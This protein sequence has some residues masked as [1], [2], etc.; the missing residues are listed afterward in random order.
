[1]V[2]G[3]TEAGVPLSFSLDTGTSLDG[4]DPGEGVTSEDMGP[5]RR[6]VTLAPPSAVHAPV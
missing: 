1:M 6:T 5:S 3:D 4:L 2:P